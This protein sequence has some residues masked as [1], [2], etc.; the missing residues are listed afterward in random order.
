AGN[1]EIK[2]EAEGYKPEIRQFPLTAG[3]SPRI[4]IR[5]QS[6]GTPS[7]AILSTTKAFFQR[8]DD[9][10]KTDQEWY[11]GSNGDFLTLRPRAEFTLTFLKPDRAHIKHKGKKLEWRASIYPDAEVDYELENDQLTRRVKANGKTTKNSVKVGAPSGDS[12]Y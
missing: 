1:Y 9:V 8:P 3:D 7:S 4:S 11:T 10:V 5:L 2:V 6:K 12:S